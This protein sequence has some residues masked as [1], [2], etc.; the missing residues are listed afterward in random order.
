MTAGARRTLANAAVRSVLIETNQNLQDHM[1]MV[2]ELN[3]LG[4][5]HDPAQVRR[6]ERQDGTFKGVA[7]YVFRR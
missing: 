6:A 7:E 2:R 3:A 4:L 5:M 1:A